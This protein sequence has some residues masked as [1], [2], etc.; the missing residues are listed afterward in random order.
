MNSP[1]WVQI[2][3]YINLLNLIGYKS[4]CYLAIDPSGDEYIYLKEPVRQEVKDINGS[5]V[6]EQWACAGKSMKLPQ[7]S[8]KVLT[9]K[10]LRYSDEPV[11]I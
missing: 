5:V 4:M 6:F 7:G 1:Y 3:L 8:I 11:K 10:N 2:Q 9:G